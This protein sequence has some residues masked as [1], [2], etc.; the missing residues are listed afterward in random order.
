VIA[1]A[2]VVL[3]SVLG[4]LMEAMGSGLDAA[5]EEIRRDAERARTNGFPGVDIDA[6][7]RRYAATRTKR[8]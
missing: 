2:L 4:S 7:H 6:V 5:Q 8:E 3:A 1:A